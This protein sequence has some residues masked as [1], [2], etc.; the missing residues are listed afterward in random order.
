MPNELNARG[1]RMKV[2]GAGL[3]RCATS[4]LQEA[5]EYPDLGFS[6]CIHM[7]HVIPNPKRAR[8]VIAALQED[9]REKRHKILHQLFDGWESTTDFPGFW[10][11][12]D[13]MDMYPDAQI[14][15]NQ[16]VGGGEAWY[17]S[18]KENLGFFGT[19]T[20]RNVCLL[21]E[22]DRLHY[23]MHAVIA[24]QWDK[25]WSVPLGPEFYG[26]HQEYVLEAAK[27]RGREV[28]V[29]KAEDGWEPLCR[30]LD[31]PV[32]KEKPFPWVNDAATIKTLTKILVVRG[33]VSW[34]ALLG[35]VGAVYWYAP[36]VMRMV[37]MRFGGGG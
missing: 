37:K 7:A 6:P 31:K 18:F 16:R 17:K 19:A 5:L 22:T 14:V 35:S 27:K 33:L 12:E 21:Y 30:F 1:P 36:W 4:S 15:L 10:F 11:V 2:I 8:L 13:L 29:W 25:R 9:D 28:L 3:S 32:P 23:R 26:Q 24:E 34:G 20:Y